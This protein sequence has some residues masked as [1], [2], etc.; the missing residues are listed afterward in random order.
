MNIFTRFTENITQGVNQLEADINDTIESVNTDMNIAV[1]NI[2]R[3]LNLNAE[4]EYQA[5][6]ADL[7]NNR[8]AVG[9]NPEDIK[10]MTDE[11]ALNFIRSRGVTNFLE[12]TPDEVAPL[13]TPPP[14]EDLPERTPEVDEPIQEEE[15]QEILQD[16]QIAGIFGDLRS[17]F[18]E[19]TPTPSVM[20][21]GF[22]DIPLS[23]AVRV[24]NHLKQQF[25]ENFKF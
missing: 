10:D 17:E 22:E 7:R 18:P 20:L 21:E 16:P 14:G 3:D 1:D 15:A 9:I 2:S 5:V 4:E 25:V 19:P 12:D 23:T 13:G 6:L 24:N 11:Q 8:S